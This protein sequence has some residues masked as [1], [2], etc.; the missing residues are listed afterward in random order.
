MKR[1]AYR[2]SRYVEPSQ[3]PLEHPVHSDS[4]KQPE[5]TGK[6]PAAFTGD[7]RAL[8]QGTLAARRATSRAPRLDGVAQAATAATSGA[9]GWKECGRIRVGEK[10]RGHW[11]AARRHGT[12]VMRRPNLRRSMPPQ[13]RGGEI[14]LHFPSGRR[15]RAAW[16][17]P[18]AP[19][20]LKHSLRANMNPTFWLAGLM[21]VLFN[22][23]FGI[24]PRWRG[25][26]RRID[27]A[28]WVANTRPVCLLA[29]LVAIPRK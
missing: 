9:P 6:A 25:C 14:A 11:G 18:A 10:V 2:S 5:Y 17:S 27:R 4:W 12:S 3:K 15:A 23:S 28:V 29:R 26:G 8:Q 22:S 21:A 13:C 7:W 16:S 1:Q 20:E 24:W 19:A